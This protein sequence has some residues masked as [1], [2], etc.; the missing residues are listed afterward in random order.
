VKL[1]PRYD[2]PAILSMDGPADDQGVLVARQR[3]RMEAL[4]A[5][6]G[7]DEWRSASRCN[8]WTVRDVVAHLVSVNAFW[9]A[10]VSAG[11]AG[12]PTR[13]LAAF[14]P[15]AHP[16]MLIEPMRAQAPR[17]VL[18]Q[19]VTSNDGFLGA[20][21]ALDDRGWSTTAETPA[22]HVSIRLLAGHALWDAWVHERDIAVPLGLASVDEPDEVESCLRYAAAVGPAL[23]ISAGNAT[24]G[25]LAVVA[26][27][28]GVAFTLEVGE[29]VVV[30]REPP[31]ADAPCL[32]GRSVELID[33]LS[34]RAP[35]PDDAPAEWHRVVH[36]LATVFDTEPATSG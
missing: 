24:S 29:S 27:D 5:D 2:G 3:R 17:A 20:L 22:G 19:F 6:L 26:T 13:V 7:D 36:S 18:E 28:P 12:T 10:S 9:E 25:Q 4:L 21:A 34:V 11:L 8:G 15:A 35:L 32:R 16:P 23:T 14:D 33:A 31:S 1:S 30:R